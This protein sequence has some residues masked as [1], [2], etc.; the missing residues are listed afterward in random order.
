[1]TLEQFKSIIIDQ[2]AAVKDALVKLE[3]NEQ[4]ILF[5]VENGNRL[6]GSLTDGDIRR[7]ILKDGPLNAS[8]EKVCFKGTFFVKT[9]YD[10]VQVKEGMRERNITYVPVVDD[11]HEIK[12]FLLYDKLFNNRVTKR[13]GHLVDADVVIMA[14]GKGT[15]LE[16]FTRVLPKPLIP[17]GDKTI[18]EYIISKF[19]PYQVDTF[20]LS[21]GHKAN[22]I[23]SYFEELSPDYK[24]SYLIENKP[25]GTVGALKKLEGK[26]NGEIILTNCDIIIEADYADL[27]KHHK[28]AGNDMTMVSSLKNYSIPYGVCKVSSD[29]KLVSLEEKPEYDLLVNTGMYV[30]NSDLLRYIPDDEFFHITDLIDKISDSHKIGIY[31]ISENSWIDVGEWI[32]YKKAVEKLSL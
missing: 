3:K 2:S 9:G 12:E 10:L 25:L 20:Y 32:E 5:V 8:V 1:M 29:G 13:P 19:L 17:V 7:W 22:I 21:L 11:N 18:L 6:I 14:G 26:T 15:R 16:P 31:P 24:I 4:K 30:L 27:L 28:D 23:R